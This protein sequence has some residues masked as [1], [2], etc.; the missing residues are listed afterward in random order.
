VRARSGMPAILPVH[1]EIETLGA[2]A[3]LD[4]RRR[5]SDP[6]GDEIL[7]DP[8]LAALCYSR[9]LFVCRHSRT[10]SGGFYA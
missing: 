6:G 8:P 10:L 5:T 2:Q 7:T 3:N 1:A 4:L 9:S